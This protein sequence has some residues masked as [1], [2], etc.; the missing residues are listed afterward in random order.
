MLQVKADGKD[1][2]KVTDLSALHLPISKTSLPLFLLFASKKFQRNPV[3]VRMLSSQ[4]HHSW[5]LIHMLCAISFFFFVVHMGQLKAT[6]KLNIHLVFFREKNN[7]QNWLPLQRKRSLRPV[8]GPR[9]DITF[10]VQVQFSMFFHTKHFT[11]TAWMLL[12]ICSSFHFSCTV[13]V[14]W[15]LEASLD[16]IS[17]DLLI[18]TPTSGQTEMAGYQRGFGMDWGTTEPGGP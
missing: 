3:S 12:Q 9:P 7:Y 15:E 16:L 1:T 11:H 4:S 5:L 8:S 13:F 18:L 6:L 17:L 2:S 10:W 14:H